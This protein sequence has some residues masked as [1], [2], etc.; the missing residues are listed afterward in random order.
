VRGLP[1]AFARQQFAAIIWDNRSMTGDYF[2]PGSAIA[3]YYRL[4]DHIPRNARPRVRTGADVVPEQIWVPIRR[5]PPPPGAKLLF[6][7]EDGKLTDWVIDGT[8]WGRAPVTG[9]LAKQGAVRHYR[10][11]YFIDSMHGG[12]AAVGSLVSPSF[13][14]DGERITFLLSGGVEP[15]V[16]HARHR[17]PGPVRNDQRQW[18]RVELRVGGVAVRESTMPGPPSERM[19]EIQW[20]VPEYLGKRAALVL[21][22]N[23]HGSW[24][25]LN[26]DEF[27][28]WKK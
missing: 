9:P 11:R 3:R 5:T 12:D 24:G 27:L 13:T 7:F 21:V 22:D 26:A 10:G 14:I 17:D 4:D 28:I 15:E 1:D 23:V 2:F 18:L 19:V 6:D 20:R 8:A 16:L 25:H